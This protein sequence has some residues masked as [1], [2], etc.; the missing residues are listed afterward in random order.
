MIFIIDNINNKRVTYI[1]VTHRELNFWYKCFT[2]CFFTIRC[3]FTCMTY[4]IN[5]FCIAL[6][7]ITPVLAV[8]Y[9][10]KN[11]LS[12]S[13]TPPFYLVL[14]ASRGV[15]LFRIHLSRKIMVILL[16]IALNN[17]HSTLYPLFFLLF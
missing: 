13:M 11:I 1:V 12:H 2:I 17:Y 14:T 15:I 8:I 9:F 3:L 10:T 5:R 4:Y 16:M 6:I 7:S